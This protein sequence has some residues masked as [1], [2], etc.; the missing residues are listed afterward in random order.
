MLYFLSMLSIKVT[1]FHEKFHKIF[2]N[3]HRTVK[4]NLVSKS[5]A[6]HFQLHFGFN[7]V[8]L[9]M[10]YRGG[11]IMDIRPTNLKPEMGKFGSSQS[12]LKPGGYLSDGSIKSQNPMGKLKH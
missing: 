6:L 10:T 11:S 1:T 3:I 8:N 2:K 5:F 12:N 7:E 4:Y 9:G